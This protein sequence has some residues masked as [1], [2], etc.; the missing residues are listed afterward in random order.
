MGFDSVEKGAQEDEHAGKR[1]HVKGPHFVHAIG[2]GA[3][4]LPS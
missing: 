3:R 2:H 4:W 1:D